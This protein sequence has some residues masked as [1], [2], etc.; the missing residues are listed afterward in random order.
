MSV[1]E[2]DRMRVV[3]HDTTLEQVHD[4][5]NDLNEWFATAVG[6]AAEA[7][8]VADLEDDRLEA[9]KEAINQSLG[10]RADGS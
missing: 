4:R 3:I 6:R 7:R 9:L 2:H 5:L 10:K 1:D 8:R